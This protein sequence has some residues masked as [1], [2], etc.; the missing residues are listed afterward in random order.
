MLEKWK[1][2]DRKVLLES[3]WITVNCDK[4]INQAG[5]QV[6]AYY[7]AHSNSFAAVFGTTTDGKVV[8]VEQYRHGSK[9]IHLEL[10]A[11]LIEDGEDPIVTA[12][13]ELEEETGFSTDDIILEKE[14]YPLAGLTDAKCHLFF[15]RN[16]VIKGKQKL[17][18]HEYINVKLIE[19]D[20]VKDLLEGNMLKGQGAM[21]AILLALQKRDWFFQSK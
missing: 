12:K 9:E 15:A 19:F 2:I 10:P 16:L 7:W 18:P 14:L 3:P 5:V 6:D 20:E 11:G 1:V 13:R 4:C 21:L 17:D 8:M